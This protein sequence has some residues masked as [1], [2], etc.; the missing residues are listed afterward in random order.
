MP[1]ILRLLIAISLIFSAQLAG[2]ASLKK[3]SSASSS[4]SDGEK[5]SSG[6]DWLVSLPVMTE[7]PQLRVHMEYNAGRS[8]GLAL[9]LATI[10]RSEELRE[11]EILATGNSLIISGA[12]ASLLLSRYSDEANLGGFFWTVG[13]G[14]KQWVAD[15]KNQPAENNDSRVGLV[16][17]G[18][19]LHHRVIGRGTTGHIRGGYRYVAREWP[20]SVGAHIG[21]RHMNSQIND[22][23]VSDAEEKKLAYEYAPISSRERRSMKNRMMT[24]P[25]ITVDFGAAF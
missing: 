1:S 3:S 17:E 14:Y 20:I 10:A 22:V 8:A 9:E 12:Q 7:R 21:L 11:T 19:H 6:R 5:K 13:A 25:D 16:D 15:W 24:T 23:N 2:A 4:S 18:G